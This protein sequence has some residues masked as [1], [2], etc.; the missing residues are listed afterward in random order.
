MKE[1]TENELKSCNGGLSLFGV[2][3]PIANPWA[4]AILTA[5]WIYDEWDDIK[6]GWNSYEPK[7][8]GK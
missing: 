2:K 8:I 1:L 4:F 7:H 6:A 3:V 5:S